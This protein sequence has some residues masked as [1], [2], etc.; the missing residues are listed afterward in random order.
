MPTYSFIICNFNGGEKLARALSSVSVQSVKDF[1]V[2]VVD[3]G[4]ND[5]SCDLPFFDQDN[6]H[7]FK[8]GFNSGFSKANNFGFSKSIGEY[9]IL[10][11]NDVVLSK[12]WLTAIDSHLK[13]YKTDS[14]ATLIL[15]KN[16]PLKIDSA[17]FEFVQCGTVFCWKNYPKNFFY[18]RPHSPIGPVAACAVYKKSAVDECGLFSDEYFAYYEDTDLALRFFLFGFK[19]SYCNNAISWHEG[20]AT[21]KTYSNFHRFHLRRTVEDVYWTNML[22]YLAFKNLFYH[23]IYELLCFFVM[24]KDGQGVT[25]LRSK[26]NFIKQ[27]PNIF[28]KRANLIQK[29]RQK[30]IYTSSIKK[31]SD[32]L[33]KIRDLIRLKDKNDRLSRKLL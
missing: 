15:Q 13:R 4:S 32:R 6:W 30:N 20:S 3:N 8:L 1:E 12:H 27:F 21:G 33:F 16:D 22:G 31:L 11:N 7:L 9:V 24:V 29:L 10:L 17:G 25:F 14:I 18:N 23:L 26:A 5:N 28:K 19:C 2:I